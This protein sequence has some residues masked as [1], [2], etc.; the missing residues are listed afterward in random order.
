MDD[1]SILDQMDGCVTSKVGVHLTPTKKRRFM[2]G[3][4][5]NFMQKNSALVVGQQRDTRQYMFAL[6]AGM[7]R[8]RMWQSV[9]QK[10]GVYILVIT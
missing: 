7:K 8:E 4:W 5:T 2:K 6:G 3:F 9:T 1:L 10:L